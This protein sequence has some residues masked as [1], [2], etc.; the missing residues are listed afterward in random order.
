MLAPG[1]IASVCNML[2]RLLIQYSFMLDDIFGSSSDIMC[3]M[4]APV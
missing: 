4:L 3:G 1:S 2:S